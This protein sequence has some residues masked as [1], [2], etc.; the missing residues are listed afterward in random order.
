MF[1]NEKLFSLPVAYEKATGFRPHISTC[2]RHR[3]NGI[4]GERLET[5]K[6]GGRRMCSAEAV[7]R[8]LAAVTA[9]ADGPSISTS[10]PRQR[11]ADISKA[12]RDCDRDGIKVG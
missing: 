7:Q 5:V 4:Q 2:H 8:F 3:I 12:E 11:D 1:Q 10:T 6:C 9:A